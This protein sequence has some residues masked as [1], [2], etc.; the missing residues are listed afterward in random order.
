[1][2]GANTLPPLSSSAN[3]GASTPE[4]LRV[5]NEVDAVKYIVN[6]ED[7]TARSNYTHSTTMSSDD[8]KQLGLRNVQKLTAK[9]AYATYSRSPSDRRFEDLTRTSLHNAQSL[10][11]GSSPMPTERVK[12]IKDRKSSPPDGQQKWRAFHQ[13]VVQ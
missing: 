1:V 3:S 2:D 10:Q 5:T 7:V 8:I 11:G 9:N 13:P 6:S 12:G 4:S